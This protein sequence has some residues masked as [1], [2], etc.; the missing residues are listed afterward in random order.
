MDDGDCFDEH[1]DLEN[2]LVRQL[3]LEVGLMTENFDRRLIHWLARESMS[4]MARPSNLFAE[5]RRLGGDGIQVLE[6]EFPYE[7]I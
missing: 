7:L 6:H 1:R 4:W 5:A 2:L 3:C